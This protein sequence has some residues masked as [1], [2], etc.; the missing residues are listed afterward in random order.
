[1]FDTTD[2][3]EYDKRYLLAGVCT[4]IGEKN[5]RVLI[6]QVV[7]SRDISDSLAIVG[8]EGISYCL[9]EDERDRV[10]LAWGDSYEENISHILQEEEWK[11]V[12]GV[13]QKILYKIGS[14]YPQL[15]VMAY[16]SQDSM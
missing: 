3:V 2:A 13:R 15:S 12:S 14:Q 6:F 5:D 4:R 8:G 16:V 1:M 9:V 10:L 7:S 11:N